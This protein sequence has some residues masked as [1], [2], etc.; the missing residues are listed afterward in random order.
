MAD[1]ASWYEIETH[2]AVAVLRCSQMRVNVA[3]NGTIE[4][5]NIGGN[6]F[7]VVQGTEVQIPP[8][9]RVQ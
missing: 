1:P 2:S 7:V 5:Q 3:E 4:V 9:T 6:R 8:E